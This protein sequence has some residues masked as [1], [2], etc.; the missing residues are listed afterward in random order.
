VVGKAVAV[1]CGNVGIAERFP[2]RW[3]G[4][5]TWAWFSRLSTDRHF[6]KAVGLRGRH[7][8]PIWPSK[9][10]AEQ[11]ARVPED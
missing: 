5:R 10:A 11:F 6:H 4:W 3:E 2:R 8:R 7:P 1:P 9:A